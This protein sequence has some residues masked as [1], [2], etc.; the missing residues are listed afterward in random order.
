MRKFILNNFSWFVYF[1]LQGI[2][3]VENPP[4]GSTSWIMAWE[5]MNVTEQMNLQLAFEIEQRQCWYPIRENEF[6]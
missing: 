2:C 4:G 5:L 1:L 3:Q 6:H